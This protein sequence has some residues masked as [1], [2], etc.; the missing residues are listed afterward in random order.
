MYE[1]DILLSTNFKRNVMYEE[2]LQKIF[3]YFYIKTFLP[4]LKLSFRILVVSWP[5][6]VS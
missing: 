1:K 6:H 4:C 5:K 3:V 2:R